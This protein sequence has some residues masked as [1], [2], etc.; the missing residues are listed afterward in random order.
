M[1]APIRSRCVCLRVPAPTHDEI[2]TVLQSV[3]SKEGMKLPAALAQRI[4]V[5]S[6]R[7]LRRA[8]LALEACR[9]HQYPLT[10]TQ[11]IQSADWQ[12]FIAALADQVLQEQ[13]PK[14]LLAVRGKL[15]ELLGNCIPPDLVMRT[16]TQ[17]LIAKVPDMV[18]HETLHNASLYEQ[19]MQSG[20]KPI[21]HIEAFVARRSRPLFL[22][23]RP[24]ILPF[25][26]AEP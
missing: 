14:N 10:D 18:R 26:N 22:A 3:A 7:N 16:L 24:S 17:H 5:S 4:A 12:L 20:S 2:C 19:R 1:I 21:F 8:I 15:Y 25:C 9:V 11:A 23:R 13:S 6:E